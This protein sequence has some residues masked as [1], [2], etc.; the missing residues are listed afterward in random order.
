[1]RKKGNT[2]TDMSDIIMIK[3]SDNNRSIRY[4][5]KIS[6]ILECLLEIEGALPAP[7]GIVLKGVFYDLSSAIEAAIDMV[8]MLCKDLG[9]VPKGDYENIQSL[10]DHGIIDD[11]LASSLAK[12]NGLRNFLVHQYNGVDDQIVLDSIPDVK[13]TLEKMIGIVEAYLSEDR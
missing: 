5:T 11:P 12:C 8:A 7:S 3:H 2:I 6:Y 10:L 1:M 9:I 13:D 4:K